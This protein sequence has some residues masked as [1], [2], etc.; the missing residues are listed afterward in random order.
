M[1][2]E[3]MRITTLA[4]AILSAF[5]FTALA[6][7]SGSHCMEGM[8]MPGC[9]QTDKKHAQSKPPRNAQPQHPKQPDKIGQHAGYDGARPP[10]SK[11]GYAPN[12]DVAG[13]GESRT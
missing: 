10:F 8:V 6:Q 13:T 7:S 2:G 9:P 5:N 11:P 12:H 1:G 3:K 4:L